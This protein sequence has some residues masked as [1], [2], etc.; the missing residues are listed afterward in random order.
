QLSLD[1]V[2]GGTYTLPPGFTTFG[3]NRGPVSTTQAGFGFSADPSADL[4]VNPSF[5]GK[6]DGNDY[7]EGNGGSDGI[8]GGLGQDDIIGGSSD[9]YGLVARSQRPD[10]ADLIFGGAGTEILRNDL[11][12]ATAD[13]GGNIAVNVGGHA[14]DADTIVGD[15]G[16]ILRLVGV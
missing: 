10:G 9:L 3:A 4:T 1:L 12:Q 15:N 5:E 2:A 16:R 14:L 6:G 11:G 7:I 13:A 8:F